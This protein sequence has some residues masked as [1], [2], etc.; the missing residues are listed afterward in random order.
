[1]GDLGRSELGGRGSS[2]PDLA[3]RVVTQIDRFISARSG[4]CFV[5]GVVPS[6]GPWY[7][8]KRHEA[9]TYQNMLLTKGR[10]SAL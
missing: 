1:L 5:V 8:G 6:C 7:R 9:C 3:L 2:P 4:M 10:L